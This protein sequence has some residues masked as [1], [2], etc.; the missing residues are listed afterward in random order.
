M[1]QRADVDAE[2]RVEFFRFFING[3]VYFSAK[4]AFDAFAVGRQHGPGHA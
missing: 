1:M 3:P 2:R 4:V